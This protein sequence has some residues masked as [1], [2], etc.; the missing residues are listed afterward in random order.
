MATPWRQGRGHESQGT[1]D[2]AGGTW[3]LHLPLRPNGET[4]QATVKSPFVPTFVPSLSPSPGHGGVQLQP[5]HLPLQ[6]ERRWQERSTTGWRAP[7]HPPQLRLVTICRSLFFFSINLVGSRAMALRAHPKR[8]LLRPQG[9]DTHLRLRTSVSSMSLSWA[10]RSSS[11][12]C[13]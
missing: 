5:P 3:D 10:A 1:W 12:R 4:S 13:W 7:V 6:Q 9:G 11:R 2:E 8:H